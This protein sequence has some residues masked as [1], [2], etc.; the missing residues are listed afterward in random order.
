[1]IAG[2]DGTILALPDS[3]NLSK[4]TGFDI[5]REATMENPASI[6]REPAGGVEFLIREGARLKEKIEDD[7][8]RLKKINLR[9][10]ESAVFTGGK[11]T[12]SLVGAGYRVKIR[13]KENI[14]WDQERVRSLREFLPA[15]KFDELFRQVYEPTSKKAIDGFLA[16]AEPEFANGLRLCMSVKPG[17]PQVTY[18]KLDK[19]E[20]RGH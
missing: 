18:E 10:A 1:M 13:L 12:V 17:A 19:A 4:P 5:H 14:A 20:D 3:S 8:A 9:L 6:I 16:F 7:L 11:R 2:E 15:D